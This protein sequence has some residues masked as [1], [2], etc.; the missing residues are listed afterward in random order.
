MSG[1]KTVYQINGRNAVTKWLLKAPSHTKRPTNIFF[2]K[3]GKRETN[4]KRGTQYHNTRIKPATQM[5][6]RNGNNETLKNM[7]SRDPKCAWG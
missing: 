6:L 7:L 2:G 4:A 3:K 1:T 5:V